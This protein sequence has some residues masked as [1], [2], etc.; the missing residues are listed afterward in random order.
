MACETITRQRVCRS[1][2]SA[3]FAGFV[4]I[5][6]AV[7]S[8]VPQPACDDGDGST[9]DDAPTRRTTSSSSEQVPLIAP[10]AHACTEPGA[11]CSLASGDNGACHS[12]RVFRPE[13][14]GSLTP[15]GWLFGHGAGQFD[16]FEFRK[17]TGAPSQQEGMMEPWAASAWS[18]DP[19]HEIDP[20]DEGEENPADD[21]PL[22]SLE[23][24]DITCLSMRTCEGGGDNCGDA[25]LGEG[26]A[27]I[28]DDHGVL[29]VSDRS[30]NDASLAD[31]VLNDASDSGCFLSRLSQG[32]CNLEGASPSPTLSATSPI[33]PSKD[34]E[35]EEEEE[36]EEASRSKSDA[37]VRRSLAF[38]EHGQAAEGEEKEE[39]E[40][41]QESRSHKGSAGAEYGW[42][43]EMRHLD[44]CDLGDGCVARGC[45]RRRTSSGG[46]YLKGLYVL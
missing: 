38:R 14:H 44:E 17:G 37:T 20:K 46:S 12:I 16:D 6:Y 13:V 28:D 9:G 39:E 22:F 31:T 26:V 24:L 35:E 18:M 34:G 32:S 41:D 2:Q 43:P 11:E 42:S 27:M 30:N 3:N 36:E 25:S 33:P 4:K 21:G 8:P 45:V 5:G 10:E 19:I 29:G 40:E 23:S 1:D 15:G 7:V